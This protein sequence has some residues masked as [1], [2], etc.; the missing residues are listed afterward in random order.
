MN[1]F[2]DQSSAIVAAI[3]SVDF[4]D[5]EQLKGQ[6]AYQQLS[7]DQRVIRKAFEKKVRRIL[8]LTQMVLNYLH[9]PFWIS[10]GTLLGIIVSFAILISLLLF[11]SRI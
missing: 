7:T 2:T 3:N 8:L 10:S 5:T 11:F 9:I 6:A 1:R 4:D